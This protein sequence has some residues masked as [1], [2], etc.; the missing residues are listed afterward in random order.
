MSHLVIK[1]ANSIPATNCANQVGH[2][3]TIV[4]ISIKDLTIAI[5][6]L[7]ALLLPF[8]SVDL[9]RQGGLPGKADLYSDHVTSHAGG[10][11]SEGRLSNCKFKNDIIQ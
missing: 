7:N 10:G 9:P 1:P 4:C 3:T 6:A 11:G 8:A 5:V 2:I